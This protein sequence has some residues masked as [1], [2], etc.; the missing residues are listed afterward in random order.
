MDIGV[1]VASHINDI[2]YVV[3]AE[4]LVYSHAWLADGRFRNGSPKTSSPTCD[5]SPSC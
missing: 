2:D 3:R 1:C 4:E 5:E